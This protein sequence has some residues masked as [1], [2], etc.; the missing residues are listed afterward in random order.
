MLQKLISS[1]KKNKETAIDKLY[2]LVHPF[3]DF[4]N[5][6][7][8]NKFREIWMDSVSDASKDKNTFAITYFAGL[9][10]NRDESNKFKFYYD[11]PSV[12][13]L[14]LGKHVQKSFGK[15]R[16]KFILI[17][18]IY[19]YISWTFDENIESRIINPNLLTI[20]TR[21]VYAEKCVD[22]GRL[23][24]IE[25]YKVPEKN[26]SIIYR[27]SIFWD[28]HMAEK[29]GLPTHIKYRWIFRKAKRCSTGLFK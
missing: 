12:H 29:Y 7:Q 3:C 10:S 17:N 14:N 27:E 22:D 8:I 11:K 23:A 26:T 4:N 2:L 28:K 9:L 15:N 21:G 6:E 25:A 1:F 19:P 24:A 5:E 18:N 16:S 20:T 13:E